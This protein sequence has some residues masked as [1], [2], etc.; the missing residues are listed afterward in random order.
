MFQNAASSSASVAD[1]IIL[2]PGL[3]AV[4]FILLL[5]SYVLKSIGLSV[6]AR[7]RGLTAFWLGWVPV[8][9]FYIL[10]RL[11]G[12]FSFFGLQVYK[13]SV[14]LPLGLIL[15]ILSGYIPILGVLVSIVFFLFCCSALYSLYSVYSPEN[16]I[17]YLLFSLL[18]LFPV[19]VFIIRGNHPQTD[20]R[21]SGY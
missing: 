19:I 11:C 14:L 1:S 10:G 15:V 8:A 17:W 16:A 6:M 7:N 21:V 2:H 5:I 20:Y 18:M 4:I 3:Y 12:P 9:D 13:A